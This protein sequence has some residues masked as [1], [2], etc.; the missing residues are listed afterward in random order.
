[1]RR[2][3]VR[4]C[5]IHAYILYV[6]RA[7]EYLR[8]LTPQLSKYMSCKALTPSRPDSSQVSMQQVI[9][10]RVFDGYIRRSEHVQITERGI[11]LS[12]CRTSLCSPFTINN[13]T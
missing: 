5:L 12:H 11:A 1:M 9:K 13:N 8:V 7:G 2:Q 3:C 10:S 4:S 6:R